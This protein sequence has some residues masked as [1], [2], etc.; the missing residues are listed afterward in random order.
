VR[1]RPT[2]T[3]SQPVAEACAGRGA[4]ARRRAA[5]APYPRH[6]PAGSSAS[7]DA[8]STTN[9]RDSRRAGD[10][11][12]RAVPSPKR[13]WERARS[14]QT[15]GRLEKRR[16]STSPTTSCQ[17]K[18]PD[19]PNAIRRVTARTTGCRSFAWLSARAGVDDGRVAGTVREAVHNSGNVPVSF[20][21]HFRYPR[22]EKLD[23]RQTAPSNDISALSSRS[24]NVVV[25]RVRAR[26]LAQA[27]RPAR[28]A[29]KECSKTS[30]SMST[31]GAE[32]VRRSASHR[33]C[34]SSL[35]RRL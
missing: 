17:R 29:Q 30:A 12:P 2:C 32:L 5:R 22:D 6:H 7:V 31:R 20:H 27:H 11:G 15:H 18:Q 9:R 19:E 14:T 35:R 4:R 23:R 24:G 1:R 10:G 16:P 26:R 28:L 21:Q 13:S 3:P 8:D 34:R 33:R 25:R